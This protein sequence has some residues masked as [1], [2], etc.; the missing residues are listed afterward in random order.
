MDVGSIN[1]LFFIGA[2]LVAASILM[3]SLSARLGVPILVIFLG[4]GMLAGVDGVGGIVF[5]DYRLAFII[6]NLALAIIL[7]DGGMR[8]RTATFR[9]ALK[10]AF[11]LATLGV[12]ITSGFTGLAAA[13]LFDLPL[14][15]GLLIGAIVGSTDAAVVFNLLNG[16]GLNERVGSTLEIESGSNDPMAMFLTVAL[17]EMLLAGQSTFGWDF[18]LSLLQQFGIGTVLGLL[19]GWLLLQLIN[20]LSVADGLYP[21]LA[22]AGGLMIFALSG[23]IG[24]SGILAI[25][26]CGLLLGNRPIRNRHGIL[27]MFDGL[28][29]L[30]QIGMFLVLGLLLTP[31]ELLPIALPALAL[32][33]WMILFARP[34]AVFVSLLPFRSFHLRERLFISWIGLR[35]AVPVILAVFPLM[36]GLENAQLFFNVAF[37]IVLV[38]LLLQGSTLAWAAKKAKVEVP[39][40]PMPVS[41]I[42]LQ[43]HTT[44]Q[45]EIFVYRLSASKW[46]VGA[47]LRELKMPPGTRIAALFRGKELLHPSGSTR[48]QVDDILCVI[49]HDEDLPALGKLFSQAPTRGQDLRF[50]GDFILEADAQLSAITALYGL[51]LGDVNGEQT[52][53]AFMAEEVGGNPVV[54]DQIE[55]NGLT[56]TVAAMDAGEVRKVGLKFPDGDKP[57]PQLMF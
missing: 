30:S 32:S 26:V 52:I 21:L 51:K 15:Q 29:W 10:P 9:V 14:L 54:G 27:H 18:L 23:A 11:S 13:W 45:W 1:H 46:C 41:R 43:V 57:G 28:A 16:K 7:L 2:L 4:V 56:W 44:S 24:G 8:T 38:S 39:P 36:A 34:L 31:S 25:Y 33:L 50:F 35:G 47:A 12:A 55:W 17:I 5:E 37:F 22:V 6:S 42:G 3:S 20:R 19:G 48:L 53:G 49:G 40:S